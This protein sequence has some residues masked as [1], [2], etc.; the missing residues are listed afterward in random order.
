MS[1]AIGLE[2]L[3]DPYSTTPNRYS[4]TGT[5]FSPWILVGYH[6]VGRIA[7]VNKID[8]CDMISL[9]RFHVAKWTFERLV[10]KLDFSVHV[11]LC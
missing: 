2:D 11:A 1:S 3:A 10:F 6:P 4:N 8:I 7:K 5:S 9:V